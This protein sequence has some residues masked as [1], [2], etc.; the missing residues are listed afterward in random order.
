ME[1]K[2]NKINIKQNKKPNIKTITLCTLILLDYGIYSLTKL[3]KKHEI[4]LKK[5]K[6]SLSYKSRKINILKSISFFTIWFLILNIIIP[7]NKYML[8]IPLIS[9]LYSLILII[10]I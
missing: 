4:C 8:K 7:F 9:N 6:C 3:F 2:N 10:I 1:T 5:N